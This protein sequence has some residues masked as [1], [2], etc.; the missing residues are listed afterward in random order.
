MTATD[1]RLSAS[2]KTESRILYFLSLV[3]GLVILTIVAVIGFLLS[4]RIGPAPKRE[5]FPDLVRWLLTIGKN[6]SML[7]LDQKGG[8]VWFSFVREGG[9]G[10]RAVLGLRVPRSVCSEA[11]LNEVGKVFES[12]GIQ[13]VRMTDN[14]S[15]AIQASLPIGDI[16]AKDCG[17]Q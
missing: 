16:W 1:Y 6:G 12:H 10:R 15:I 8:E 7:R 17:A 2:H 11:V 5:D 13:Y 14:P 4:R 9:S 3:V